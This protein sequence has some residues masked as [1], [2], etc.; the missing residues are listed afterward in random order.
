MH[1]NAKQRHIAAA[2]R[3]EKDEVYVDAAAI[4]HPRKDVI[5]KA[6]SELLDL[7]SYRASICAEN[8][9]IANQ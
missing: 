4:S 3:V 8:A 2:R 6:E 5:K 7:I 9:K 1:K